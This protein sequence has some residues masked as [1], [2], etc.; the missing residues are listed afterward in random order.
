VKSRLAFPAIILALVFSTGLLPADETVRLP[1]DEPVVE[2]A[3]P[4]GWEALRGGTV[5]VTARPKRLPPGSAL[6]SFRVMRSSEVAAAF[7]AALLEHVRD[8]DVVQE[9]VER[10]GGLPYACL[11]GEARSRVTGEKLGFS[12]ILFKPRAKGPL[13]LPAQFVQDDGTP[14]VFWLVAATEEAEQ[15]IGP[16]VAGVLASVRPVPR[17]AKDR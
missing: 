8:P 5:D 17:P 11:L 6:L 13:V 12:I 3:L 14:L 1:E 10:I 15:V 9:S 2:F 4:D 7:Q 16:D